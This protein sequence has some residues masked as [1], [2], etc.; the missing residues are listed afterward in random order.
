MKTFVFFILFLILFSYISPQNST[1]ATENS[2]EDIKISFDIDPF[3]DFDFGNVITLDDTNATS[4]LK[5]HELIYVL[6]Y[7][8]LCEPCYEFFPTYVN[9]SKYAEEKNLN[10]KF[11]KIEGM[12]NPNISQEFQ[13][14][15]FP[16]LF[17]VYN[18]SKIFYEGKRTQEA[19]LKFVDRKLKKD[20]ITLDSLSQIKDYISSSI[21][22]LLCTI[23]N[24]THT[25]YNSFE[26]N[27]KMRNNMDFIVCTSDECIKEYRENMVLFKEFDEKIN[28]YTKEIGLIDNATSF[29]L[30]E[31][32]A[33]YAVE[34]GAELSYYE[35]NMMFEYRRNMV[36]FFRNSS[37]EN[38][39]KYD[40]IMKE[41][42]L[43][44]RKNK[45]YTVTA[46]IQGDPVQQH[47][48]RSFIVLPIDLPVLLIYDQN[49]N[50]KKGDLPHLYILRNLKEE[51]IT[52]EYFLNFV[53]RVIEKKERKTLYSQPPRINYNDNGIK[54]VIGRTFDSDV[55]DN[56]NNV[57]LALINGHIYSPGT[58]NVLNI[59]RNLS[60][61]YNEE[62]DKILFAYSDAQVNE[63][64]DVEL[65][66]HIPPLVL[67]YTNAM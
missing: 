32:L 1:N 36:M 63:P 35:I 38:I 20:I 13:L 22:T 54:I 49:I 39:T 52:K 53:N 28:I 17:L 26:N 40:K 9:T 55:I 14:P 10:I 41:L 50:P 47:I 4:E 56:K 27:A 58:D 65:A 15:Q 25:L 61:K 6:F 11:A 48:A 19:L 31:F 44:L 30:N 66:G 51:Q 12:G 16:A 18:G 23:K 45:F 57:L 2:T 24:K 59:M 21:M 43:E 29:S 37:D 64:R 7:T 34:S 33:T 8:L 67:L 5:K 42:G 46:D 62:E 3:K 60:K